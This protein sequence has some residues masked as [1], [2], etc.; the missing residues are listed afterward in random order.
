MIS[1]R[2]AD[3]YTMMAHSA[4]ENGGTSMPISSG[5]RK[6]AQK[7]IMIRGMDRKVYT[8]TVETAFK[9]P[10]SLV[11]AIP[12]SSAKGKAPARP[13]AASSNVPAKPPSGPLG[14]EPTR[15]IRPYV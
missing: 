8:H 12:I 15:N 3:S 2:N 1:A 4:V 9:G 7:M 5:S 13:S 6:Y 11:R 10:Q 14:H